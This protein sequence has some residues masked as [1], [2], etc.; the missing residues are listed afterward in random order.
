MRTLKKI[1]EAS[2]DLAKLAVGATYNIAAVAAIIQ[3]AGA[4]TGYLVVQQEIWGASMLIV[5]FAGAAY[6]ILE[7]EE[8]VLCKD[9]KYSGTAYDP[10]EE[11]EV[12]YC[13][14]DIIRKRVRGDHYCSFGERKD[15]VNVK[16]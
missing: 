5:L 1:M 14:C 15:E 10:F 11:K 9:C 3:S 6:H 4:L 8:R 2:L 12:V 16:D 7:K 13:D